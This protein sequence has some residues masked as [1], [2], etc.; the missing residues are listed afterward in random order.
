MNDYLKIGKASEIENKKDR[1]IY[2]TFEVFP[3]LLSWAS[4]GLLILLSFTKPFWVAVF[5][6]AFDIYWVI[7]VAYFYSHLAAAFSIMKKV[8]KTDWREKLEA[9]N[10]NWK[11]IYQ[12]VVLPFYKE[13][14][15]VI[16]PSVEALAN[17]N[18]PIREKMIVVL[19][20]EERA[21]EEAQKISREI[22]T[23]YENRFFKF[24]TTAHPK[25]IPGELAGK[26]SN[27]AW[28]GKKARALIDQLQIPYENIV[29]SSFDIDTVVPPDISAA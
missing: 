14:I 1:F 18:Y 23:E 20:S 24:L 19:A 12:L 9:E 26:G 4:I 5:I 15:D 6:I 16:K 27:T 7:R 28:A 22:K 13:G 3:G 29:V 17:S 10:Q 8:K 2:R 25:D 11:E 21:G